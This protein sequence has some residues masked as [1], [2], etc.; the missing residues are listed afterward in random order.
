MRKSLAVIGAGL[1]ILVVDIALELLILP[2]FYRGIPTPFPPT[3]K[4]IGGIL[5]PATFF[6]LLL[7]LPSILLLVYLAGKMG[8]NVQNITLKIKQGWME[9]LFLLVLFVSGALMWWYALVLL[10]FLISGIYLVI[11]EIK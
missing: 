5:L 2:I 10:P 7:A 8:Y 3:E 11:A 6:H 1:L 4:P 9:I